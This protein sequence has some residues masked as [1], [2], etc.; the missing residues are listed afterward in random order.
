MPP[1]PDAA[2]FFHG[3]AADFDSLYTG[4]R[5]RW[6]RWL[7]ERFR[8]DIWRRFALSFQEFG[9]L[10]DKSVLDIGCGSG[11]YLAEAL[12]R[13]AQLVTGVD[14][15][16]GMLDLVRHKLKNSADKERCQLVQGTFPGVDLHPH[17]HVLVMGVMDYVAD[18]PTFLQ[19]LKTLVLKSAA[20]SFPSQHWL[21]TPVRRFRYR[22][23]GCPVYF[24]DADQIHWLCSTAG[25]SQIRIQKIP[26][27]GLDFFVCLFP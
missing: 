14:P 5:S 4:K 15:A 27:A 19:E 7:D 3:F 13:G 26:G 1:R 9:D 11:P 6:Q 18:A 10:R 22:L 8:G 2:K 24:Y 16:P 21:R 17:D 25:F 20:L 23:R 12:A